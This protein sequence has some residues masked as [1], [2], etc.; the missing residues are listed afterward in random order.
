MH[1]QDSKSA[2]LAS[3]Y[4]LHHCLNDLISR[5][6][7]LARAD[8]NN[9]PPLSNQ[10]LNLIQKINSLSR[11]LNKAYETSLIVHSD[12]DCGELK[13]LIN[14]LERL[15]QTGSERNL[16]AVAR[17][18]DSLNYYLTQYTAEEVYLFTRENTLCRELKQ[19]FDELRTNR[20]IEE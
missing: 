16:P 20:F 14:S 15:P 9:H 6:I 4:A 5:N 18:V 8:L 19:L 12:G 2:L 13:R 7:A 1:F 11:N 17:L 10:P 3:Q